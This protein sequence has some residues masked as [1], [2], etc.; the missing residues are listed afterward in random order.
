MKLVE[1]LRDEELTDLLLQ[2]EE[3]QMRETFAG[4]P[5]SLRSAAERPGWFWQRQRGTVR[6][7]IATSQRAWPALTAMWVGAAALL[8]LAFALLRGA[9]APQPV[10]AQA[11]TDSDQQL[12]VGVEQVM[13]SEVPEALEPSA[14]LASEIS[15]GANTQ[16]RSHQG[17]KENSNE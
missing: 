9:P 13:Q 7:R 10:Q 11:Q 5:Q 16:Y 2:S 17:N 14:L 6:E 12:L 8:V 4:A 3:R 1:Q 15:A